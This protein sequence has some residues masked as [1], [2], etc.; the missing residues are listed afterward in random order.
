MSSSVNMTSECLG[1][2][3]GVVAA[4]KFCGVFEEVHLKNRLS[5]WPRLPQYSVWLLET[6]CLK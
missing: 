4:D 2:L 5:G 1:S 3:V 6:F